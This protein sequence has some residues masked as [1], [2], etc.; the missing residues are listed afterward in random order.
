MEFEKYREWSPGGWK[1]LAAAIGVR[2]EQL[3]VNAHHGG[4]IEFLSHSD[5]IELANQSTGLSDQNDVECP[6]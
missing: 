3:W 4:R 2:P 1:Q 5:S 6:K